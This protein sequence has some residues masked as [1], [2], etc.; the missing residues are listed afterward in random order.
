MFMLF[1]VTQ[2]TMVHFMI[3]FLTLRFGYSQLLVKKSLYLLVMRM[4]ITLSSWSRSL[5]LIGTSVL[6]LK[7]VICRV[8]SSWCTVPLTLL[9]AG[10]TL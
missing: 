7:F 2:G 5:L 8:V 6:L 3:V 10:S 9:V 4:L 1:A